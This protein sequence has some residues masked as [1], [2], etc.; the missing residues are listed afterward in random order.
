[1]LPAPYHPCKFAPGADAFDALVYRHGKVATGGSWKSP[2]P[3]LKGSRKIMIEKYKGY[4]YFIPL[5]SETAFYHFP[6]NVYTVVF[7]S[8]NLLIDGAHNGEFSI[9]VFLRKTNT[10]GFDRILRIERPV[11][12]GKGIKIYRGGHL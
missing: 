9:S 5:S 10:I 8:D 2:F 12:H 11:I 3:V 4:V 6:Q 1:M 7:D